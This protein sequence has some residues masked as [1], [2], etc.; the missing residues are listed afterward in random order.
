[1][2][3]SFPSAFIIIPQKTDTA[4]RFNPLPQEPFGNLQMNFI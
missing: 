4:A 1:M 2:A 3:D